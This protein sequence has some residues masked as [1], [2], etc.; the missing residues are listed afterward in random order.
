MPAVRGVSRGGEVLINRCRGY[1]LDVAVR[2][3]HN[4]KVGIEFSKKFPA[5]EGYPWR[6]VVR[7]VNPLEIPGDPRTVAREL[8]KPLA[9]GQEEIQ[10]FLDNIATFKDLSTQEFSRVEIF[11]SAMIVHVLET[12]DEN[13][14]LTLDLP[15][16]SSV[17]IPEHY[18][19]YWV[20]ETGGEDSHPRDPNELM[21]YYQTNLL[22]SYLGDHHSVG[23]LILNGN[24]G[25]FL[26]K[27]ATGG[28]IILN[29]ECGWRSCRGLRITDLLGNPLR[30]AEIIINGIAGHDLLDGAH[31]G[32]VYINDGTVDGQKVT[33]S[34]RSL[35]SGMSPSRTKAQCFLN[36]RR[37]YPPKKGE[38]GYSF[39]HLEDPTP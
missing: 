13:S 34:L 26:A 24:A 21:R 8:L 25:A 28:R 10:G 20:R 33:G 35:S 29:G 7:P 19:T 3:S 14:T 22:L 9:F 23:T 30:G 6:R 12:G 1:L 4:L 5:S 11:L 27:E 15:G 17:H 2:Q 38:K 31:G 36:G 16:R 18:Y 37:I 39:D 32:F